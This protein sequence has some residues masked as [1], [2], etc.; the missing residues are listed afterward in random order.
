MENVKGEIKRAERGLAQRM[1]V[2]REEAER[3][4]EKNSDRRREGVYI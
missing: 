4:W 3:D 2:L 1:Y